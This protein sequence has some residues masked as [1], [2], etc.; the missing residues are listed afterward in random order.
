MAKE[1]RLLIAIPSTDKWDADFGMS[2]VFLT[3]FIAS[4]GS[5]K[6][7]PITFRVHNK[8]GSILAN[9]RQDLVDQAVKNHATHILFIDSDQ[10]FPADTFHRLMHHEK[11]VVACNVATKATPSNP[12]ARLKGDGNN[13]VPLYT[14]PEDKDLVEVWRV[15]TGVMLIDVNVFKREGIERPYFTQRWNAKLDS[16][17]GEDWAFC[18]M[19]EKAGVKLYVD[20]DLSQEI[21]HVGRL[22]Y[23]HDLVV[24][25]EE[26]DVASGG[27]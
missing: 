17:V 12:T 3:N 24:P 8:R 11:K 16:Y 26:R 19:L 1:I 23:G 4:R 10:V 5:I 13:G 9:M 22:T 21:G 18:E 14:T 15:G 6:G 25:V 20:Q 2:L 7:K 27:S